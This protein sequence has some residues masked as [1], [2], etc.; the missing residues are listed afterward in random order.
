MW[1]AAASHAASSVAWEDSPPR[2]VREGSSRGWKSVEEWDQ[3]SGFRGLDFLTTSK[4]ATAEDDIGF[5]L[6]ASGGKSNWYS[7]NACDCLYSII[8]QLSIDRLQLL[9]GLEPHG[10]AG[11]NG[12]LG[13]GAGVA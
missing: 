8:I 10:L 4:S 12:H 9:A 2:L 1:R 5:R 11:G 3:T 13:A 7:G 6:S